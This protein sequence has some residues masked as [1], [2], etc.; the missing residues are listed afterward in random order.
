MSSCLEVP[1]YPSG[2]VSRILME[3]T[4]SLPGQS[5]QWGARHPEQ[6]RHVEMSNVVHPGTFTKGTDVSSAHW[7]CV[8]WSLDPVTEK[9]KV[10]YQAWEKTTSH[11][12]GQLRSGNGVMENHQAWI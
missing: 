1:I 8:M 7:S 5:P 10:N 2:R 6:D 12:E 11:T 9:C 4:V 3:L